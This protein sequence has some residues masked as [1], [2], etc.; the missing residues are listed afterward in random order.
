MKIR[1][2]KL[3]NWLLMSLMGLLGLSAC[4]SQS[5]IEKTDKRE[6][7]EPKEDVLR[8]MY[9][10]PVTDRTRE[11]EVKTDTVQVKQP[12]QPVKPREEQVTVY[13]VPTVDYE[14][15]G[16]VVNSAG[17]PVKGIEVAI[18]AGDCD[19]KDLIDDVMLPPNGKN[20][21]TTDANG[22]FTLLSSDRPWQRQRLLVRDID[23][24]QNGSYQN[25]LI[26]V[27]FSEPKRT[28]DSNKWKVGVK[29]AEVT[30]KLK[31]K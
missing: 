7:K 31:K 12:K 26:D 6:K 28:E 29:A 21:D 30:V 8:P 3:K 20:V 10:V 19:S 23:G 25:E 18:I 27:E 14:V 17:K 15:K 24:K 1:F 22:N 5:S 11:V 9:G 2:L 4:Q 13:G 16:R